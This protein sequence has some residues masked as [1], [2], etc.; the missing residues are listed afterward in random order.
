MRTRTI[1]A[2]H[3][4]AHARLVAAVA[5]LAVAATS[6]LFI[7]PA[8]DASEL[9]TGS[10]REISPAAITDIGTS[11][12]DRLFPNHYIQ[13]SNDRYR[14]IMQSDGNLVLYDRIDAGACW[15]SNTA[16]IDGVWAEWEDNPLVDFYPHLDL[17]SPYGQLNSW[18]GGYTYLHKT[19]GNVSINNNGEVWLAYKKFVSC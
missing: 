18:R 19:G 14:F 6:L 7:A 15:A 13:S 10:A 3:Q 5:A 11:F 4:K 2:V 16:G 12:N 8:A 17:N 9:R 1:L